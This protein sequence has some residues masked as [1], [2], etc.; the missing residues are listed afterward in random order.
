MDKFYYKCENAIIEYVM[1]KF[2]HNLKTINY[3]IMDVIK[4]NRLAGFDNNG[5]NYAVMIKLFKIRMCLHL[6]YFLEI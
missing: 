6:R 2:S 4:Y 5:K 3:F 1:D